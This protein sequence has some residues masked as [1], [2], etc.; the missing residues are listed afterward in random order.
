[1]SRPKLDEDIIPLSEFRANA[2]SCVN[3]VQQTRRP[4]IL[5]QRGHSAAVLVDVSEYEKLVEEV[6]FLRD[7]AKADR[8][9][10]EGLG[11]PHE[12]ARA[13]LK[14]PSASEP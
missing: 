12:E 4:I 11:I 3:R 8:Q 1:M 6:E 2:A 9:I 5:T 14:R 7:V 13:L 10:A